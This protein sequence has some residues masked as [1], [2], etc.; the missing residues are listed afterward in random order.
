VTSGRSEHSKLATEE[1]RSP[2]KVESELSVV[3]LKGLVGLGTEISEIATTEDSR[4]LGGSGGVKS[5]DSQVRGVTHQTVKYSP[6]LTLDARKN[7]VR[8]STYRSE[9][10]FRRV[11]WGRRHGLGSA[12]S[13]S[14]C[15]VLT[16]NQ[17]L[18][19]V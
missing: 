14:H 6:D 18:R 8:L 16:V 7:P 2:E 17:L 15:S 9:D 1:E 4:S 12:L 5:P 10:F 19:E 13:V 3:K 11:T